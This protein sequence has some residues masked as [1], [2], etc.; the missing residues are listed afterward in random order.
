M[1]HFGRPG[2]LAFGDRP[3]VQRIVRRAEGVALIVLLLRRG[4]NQAGLRLV[5]ANR[6]D[7]P[8]ENIV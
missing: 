3:A 1:K 8:G 4:V 5:C 7:Y 6:D 2:L